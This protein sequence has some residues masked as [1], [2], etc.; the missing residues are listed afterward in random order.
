MQ[1]VTEILSSILDAVAAPGRR[2]LAVLGPAMAVAELA[3]VVA[4]F[5][6]EMDAAA[7]HSCTLDILRWGGGI[8]AFSNVLEHVSSKTQ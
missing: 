1:K 5:H 4:L 8:F 7:F 6:G 3:C 2:K